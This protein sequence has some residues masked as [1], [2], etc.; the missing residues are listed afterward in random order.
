MTNGVIS[1]DSPLAPDVRELLE[2]HLAFTTATSPPEH[3]HAMDANALLDPAVSFFSYRCDGVLLGVGALKR[4]DDGHAEVKS[5]HTA[6][7]VRGTG[8]GRAMLEHLL[9]VARQHG[10]RRVSLETGTMAEFAP[11]RALYASAGFAPCEPFADYR[12]SPDNTFMTLAIA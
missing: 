7:A 3:M 8:I 6:Q 10:F 12:P 1:A 4:L 11:A 5:M 9:A 2:R